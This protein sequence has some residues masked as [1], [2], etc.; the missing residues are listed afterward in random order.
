MKLI[1]FERFGLVMFLVILAALPTLPLNERIFWTLIVGIT[2]LLASL[3][4]PQLSLREIYRNS[5]ILPYGVAALTFVLSLLFNPSTRS[6]LGLEYL[7][8][9]ISFYV[10]VG[11]LLGT[12]RDRITSRITNHHQ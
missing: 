12:T 2:N 6:L 7:I 10:P 8:I 3:V 4:G 1:T 5:G 9:F 11:Y